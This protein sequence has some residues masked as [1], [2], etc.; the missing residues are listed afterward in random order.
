[1][2]LKFAYLTRASGVLGCICLPLFSVAILVIS[3]FA[4]SKSKMSILSLICSGFLLPG[5]TTKPI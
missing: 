2:G 1:M 5:I 3:S 4:S